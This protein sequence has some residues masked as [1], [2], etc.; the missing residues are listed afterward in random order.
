[1]LISLILFVF[2]S[3]ARALTLPLTSRVDHMTKTTDAAPVF[4]E[5][6]FWI[7]NILEILDPRLRVCASSQ[8]TPPLFELVDPVFYY[9][10]LCFLIS[11]IIQLSPS[12]FLRAQEI[13]EILLNTFL[14]KCIS[15]KVFLNL[16]SSSLPSSLSLMGDRLGPIVGVR[17]NLQG[18]R[19]LSPSTPSPS[20]LWT[21]VRLF[22]ERLAQWPTLLLMSPWE[23]TFRFT[24][25]STTFTTKRNTLMT[26][27][28]MSRWRGP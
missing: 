18:R 4:L 23:W 9:I 10:I 5:R 26:C 24:Q 19:R 21:P 16:S 11:N 2:Y 12:A 6:V 14:S 28:E 17:V 27:W 22:L 1:M 8:T 15:V 7:P 3:Y 25:F 13:F 20:L